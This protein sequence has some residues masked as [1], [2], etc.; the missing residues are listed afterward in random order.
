MELHKDQFIVRWAYPP[1]M[2]RPYRT[3]LCAVFWRAVLFMPLAYL[4]LLVASPVLLTFY[5]FV[6]Y[7]KPRLRR[8]SLRLTEVIDKKVQE[9][10]ERKYREKE[11]GPRSP[12]TWSVLWQGA[13]AVK[14]K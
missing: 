14:G 3:S 9:R 1:F 6:K 12:S 8:W 13:K 11:R 2:R 5:A 10:W 4:A 7:A